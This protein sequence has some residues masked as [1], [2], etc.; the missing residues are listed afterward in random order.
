MADSTTTSQGSTRD[1][2]FECPSCQKSMV[3]DESASGMPIPCPGCGAGV[4]VPPKSTTEA[5]VPVPGVDL[6]GL[7]SRLAALGS[8]LKELQTQRTE[9][10]NNIGVRL[11]DINRQM[12]LLARLET[13]Q[14]QVLQ[15][16]Q[17]LVAQ[18]K[19]ARSA[20]Q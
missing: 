3:I 17:E 20:K 8:K 14:Q 16:W 10:N 9:I 12:V 4:I 5:A 2:F 18:V 7:E 13:S 1:I 19:A 15:D 11:N 6:A